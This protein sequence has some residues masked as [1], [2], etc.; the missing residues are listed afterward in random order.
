MVDASNSG[1]GFGRSSVLAS[2]GPAF[3]MSA[4]LHTKRNPC[5]ICAMPGVKEG[6]SESGPDMLCYLFKPGFWTFPQVAKQYQTALTRQGSAVRVRQRPPEFCLLVTGDS[7]YGLSSPRSENASA[8]TTRPHQERPRASSSSFLEARTRQTAVIAE[9]KRAVHM[10]SRRM[11]MAPGLRP[12][13]I[14]H[15]LALSVMERRLSG[16]VAPEEPAS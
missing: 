9:S 14:S 11:S 10:P 13:A 16:L 3:S 15:S 4:N 2:P 5:R 7:P 8:T 12:G 6:Q 1:V